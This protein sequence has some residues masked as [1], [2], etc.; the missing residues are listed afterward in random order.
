MSTQPK[1]RKIR[2]S[3]TLSL[4]SVRFIK[5]TRRRRGVRSD[6]EALELLLR[7]TMLETRRQEIDAA[8]TE[9]YDTASDEEL[10]EQRRWTEGVGQSIPE[11]WDAA[12]IPEK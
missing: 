11:C 12:S 6:S 4:D 5:K 3:F 1:A 9:Y 2:R 7:D 10:A 8:C